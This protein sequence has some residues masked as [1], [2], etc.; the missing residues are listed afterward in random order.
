MPPSNE[1]IAVTRIHPTKYT[2]T[3]TTIA[4]YPDETNMAPLKID[5]WNLG[6]SGFGNHDFGGLC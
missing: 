5:P 2:A 3:A 6:D 1:I 4:T